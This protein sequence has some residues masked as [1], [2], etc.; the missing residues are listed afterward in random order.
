MPGVHQLWGFA[1]LDNSP[2]TADFFLHLSTI[3]SVLHDGGLGDKKLS[4]VLEKAKD[5]SFRCILCN[6]RWT[7]REYLRQW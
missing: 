1:G 3:I 4:V 7:S 2:A 5:G 6:L